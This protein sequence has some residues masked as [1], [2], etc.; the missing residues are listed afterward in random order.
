[1]F[2]LQ[3]SIN[4]LT[5]RRLWSNFFNVLCACMCVRARARA[6]AL[7]CVSLCH[8][9]VCVCASVSLVRAC[10]GVEWCDV[11]GGVM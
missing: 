4:T 8:M 7:V 9:C 5:S 3:S 1:M 2:V 11:K 6:R 10:V